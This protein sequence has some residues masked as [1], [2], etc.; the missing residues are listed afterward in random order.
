MWTAVRQAVGEK[1]DVLGQIDFLLILVGRSRSRLEIDE[2]RRDML[3]KSL[4]DL[5]ALRDGLKLEASKVSAKS[6]PISCLLA[7]RC[8]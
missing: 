8:F 3:K 5:K 7:C 2:F 4:E 6:L 1:E